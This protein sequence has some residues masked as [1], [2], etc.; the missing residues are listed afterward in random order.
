MRVATKDEY[1]EFFRVDQS[2]AVRRF[3]IP[4]VLLLTVGPPLIL[5][6]ATM[7]QIRGHGVLG[8]IGAALMMCGLV[9]G[10]GGIATLI[11]DDRYLAVTERGLVIHLGQDDTF[12]AW[13]DLVAIRAAGDALVLEQ[14]SGP[15]IS[16]PFPSATLAQIADR[17]DDWRRKS[18]WNL[19]PSPTA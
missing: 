6:S 7:K 18:A 17:L 14:K 13:E 1:L 11:F 4:A 16:V 5:F 9:T 10:F 12:H 8:F 3:L 2:K 15:P 19:A